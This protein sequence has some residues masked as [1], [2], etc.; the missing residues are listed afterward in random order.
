MIVG[1]L[2]AME[3]GN[4]NQ[5]KSIPYAIFKYFWTIEGILEFQI[6]GCE[7]IYY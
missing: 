2:V 7:D 3:T 6:M 4:D 5:S 1:M